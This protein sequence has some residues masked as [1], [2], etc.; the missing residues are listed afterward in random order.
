MERRTFLT[1]GGA[2]LLTQAGCNTTGQ[3]ADNA[4]KA[5]T[6]LLSSLSSVN[7]RSCAWETAMLTASGTHEILPSG[8]PNGD[9]RVV[10]QAPYPSKISVR[11]KNNQIVLR[12][13]DNT[14]SP[15]EGSYRINSINLAANKDT[16]DWDV[17]IT[18]PSS[19]RVEPLFNLDIVNV[20]INPAHGG[21]DKNSAPLVLQ[22]ARAPVGDLT[23]WLAA[24][25][26]VANCIVWENPGGPVGQPAW[27]ADRKQKLL[28]RFAAAW[29]TTFLLLEDPPPN[30]ATLSD[31]DPPTTVLSESDAWELYLTYVSYSL[32]AEIGGWTSWSITGYSNDQLAMLLDSRQM[33]R[34]N[35][36]R[37]GYEILEGNGPNGVIP[38]APWT[39]LLFLYENGIYTCR[40]RVDVIA[41]LIDWCR[42]NLVHFSGGFEAKNMQDQWQYRGCPPVFRIIRGTPMPSSTDPNFS[43]VLHRTGGCWGTTAFLRAVLRVVNIPVKLDEH[44]G[45]ASPHFSTEGLYLSHGDDPYNRLS[46]A[47]PPFPARELLIDQAKRDGWFGNNVPAAQQ[48]ANVGRRT[49]ELG[50][51]YLSNEL[52]R[53]HCKDVTDGNSHANS[54]VFA[55]LNRAFT[56]AELE[57]QDLWGRID[58]KI[59]GFGGCSQIP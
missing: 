24:N 18:P 37:S 20:S 11:T 23:T 25:P 34:W 10:F 55:S 47:T 7:P 6:P 50:V 40:S 39:T 4:P 15:G 48:T 41:R 33:F 43:R 42:D 21:T 59:A 26:N 54:Q 28:D 58:A 8:H 29:N 2:L 53:N 22:L 45:H 27:H 1:T 9:V 5:Q 17:T 49:Q 35:N 44:Q 32:A 30:T 52:L 57:A 46:K 12:E 19:Q 51:Q 38:A 31:T 3:V 56:L 16:F 14:Q 36:A 13:F